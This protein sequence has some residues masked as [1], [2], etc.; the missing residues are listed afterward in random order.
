M[1]YMLY[2]ILNQQYEQKTTKAT[3]YHSFLVCIYGI[4]IST[5]V[6]INI[7]VHVNVLTRKQK[8]SLSYFFF[9]R[10]NETA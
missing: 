1:I 4:Y 7:C 10:N 5:Y 8:I 6:Y 3:N 9:M 2:I